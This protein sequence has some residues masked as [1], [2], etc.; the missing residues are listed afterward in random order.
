MNE[1]LTPEQRDMIM[2]DVIVPFA[3]A[4]TNWDG[5]SEALDHITTHTEPEDG[6]K[7]LSELFEYEDAIL[8][9]DAQLNVGKE[10]W[11]DIMSSGPTYVSP[12]SNKTCDHTEL[13]EGCPACYEWATGTP[14]MEEKMIDYKCTENDNVIS[15]NKQENQYEIYTDGLGDRIVIGVSD[16]NSAREFFSAQ[17]TG[18][19]CVEGEAHTEAEDEGCPLCKKP[20]VLA[21]WQNMLEE[22]ERFMMETERQIA[23]RKIE[24][25]KTWWANARPQKPM[26]CDLEDW[27]Q[28]EDK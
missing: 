12:I 3:G 23:L 6:P 20:E 7:T 1:K 22:Y 26:L 2:D 21:Y 5:I 11:L 8:T 16:M 14:F 18:V 13:T 17:I 19:P 25:F 28:Q 15:L 9:E 4:D 27:L 24:E 10:E